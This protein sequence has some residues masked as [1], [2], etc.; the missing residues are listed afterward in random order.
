M[1]EVKEIIKD[2]GFG[3]TT[4][5]ILPYDERLKEAFEKRK[6]IRDQ[7]NLDT[8]FEIQPELKDRRAIAATSNTTLNKAIKMKRTIA[9][10]ENDILMQYRKDGKK[11]S[12]EIKGRIFK[13]VK[14]SEDFTAYLSCTIPWI[15][16]EDIKRNIALMLDY[17]DRGEVNA[18]PKELHTRYL[19]RKG[20]FGLWTY[21]PAFS[22]L[23]FMDQLRSGEYVADYLL[24]EIINWNA[25]SLTNLREVVEGIN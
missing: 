4:L 15:E 20:T 24:D 8:D 12:H 17:Y 16:H 6:R 5:K 13:K 23:K 25:V 1:S 21:R 11:V 9:R 2:S 3:S 18:I 10:I 19:L 22:I 14:V 7:N